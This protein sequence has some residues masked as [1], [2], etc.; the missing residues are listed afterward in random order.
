MRY[1]PEETLKVALLSLEAYVLWMLFRLVGGIFTSGD[2]LLALSL[3]AGLQLAGQWLYAVLS[4]RVEKLEGMRVTF[5]GFSLLL[6]FAVP[7]LMGYS[8]YSGLGVSL[9]GLSFSI[10]QLHMFQSPNSILFTL[11]SKQKLRRMAVFTLLVANWFR[12]VSDFG[13]L[14][15]SLITFCLYDL[16]ELYWLNGYRWRQREFDHMDAKT[17]RIGFGQAIGSMESLN[18]PYAMLSALVAL[19]MGFMALL[20][21]KLPLVSALFKAL[22]DLALMVVG[23]VAQW[24]YVALDLEALSKVAKVAKGTT[25]DI[26]DPSKYQ[27]QSAASAFDPSYEGITLV[28]IAL[29]ILVIV[30][31]VYRILKGRGRSLERPDQA[32]ADQGKLSTLSLK[33]LKQ[34]RHK[35]KRT[36][37]EVKVLLRQHYRKLLSSLKA[38]GIGLEPGE[39]ADQI[40]QKL[41]LIY[42]EQWDLI[43]VITEG[44]C[45]QRYGKGPEN[46]A[47]VLSA[48]ESLKEE[49]R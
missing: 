5:M 29:G 9:Y 13:A 8:L 45:A 22:G 39:T 28:L 12:D 47:E 42:P 38:K 17:D 24:V 10:R 35:P 18:R 32:V 6:S 25:G 11:Q 1:R 37:E 27:N 15:L 2:Y 43:E 16:S 20:M 36:D 41:N 34:Q 26:K 21:T 33:P 44:Y 23:G 14:S 7:L 49:N 30:L 3:L 31:L 19:V 4:R 46:L 40:R 48:F